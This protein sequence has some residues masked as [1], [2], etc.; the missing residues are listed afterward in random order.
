MRQE[1]TFP[2]WGPGTPEGP[3]RASRRFL[4]YMLNYLS[5]NSQLSLVYESLEHEVKTPETSCFFSVN[6]IMIVSF[7]FVSVDWRT[8][9][10]RLSVC[11]SLAARD[12][13]TDNWSACTQLF[14]KDEASSLLYMCKRQFRSLKTELWENSCRG[15]D[16]QKRCFQCLLCLTSEC[17]S[18]VTMVLVK[19]SVWWGNSGDVSERHCW[20]KGARRASYFD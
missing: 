18:V 4:C 5:N 13:Q 12:L 19:S 2:N 3:C 6:K 16:I 17:L 8:S 11:D 15:E 7:H 20:R 1:V 14:V 9:R 10:D